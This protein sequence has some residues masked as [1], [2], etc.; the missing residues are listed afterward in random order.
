MGFVRRRRRQLLLHLQAGSAGAAGLQHHRAKGTLV[1]VAVMRKLPGFHR[2]QRHGQAGGL[3]ERPFVVLENLGVA[4]R[5][6]QSPLGVYAGAAARLERS[7]PDPARLAPGRPSP[8][9]GGGAN[10]RPFSNRR[11]AQFGGLPDKCCLHV[12]KLREPRRSGQGKKGQYGLAIEFW[13][14]ATVGRV[15]G[16]QIGHLGRNDIRHN[17]AFIVP[18]LCRELPGS[19][20]NVAAS[21]A[22]FPRLI[23]DKR[24]RKIVFRQQW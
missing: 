2:P 13:P 16:T 19:I 3:G 7:Q 22:D 15:L 21:P 10:A 11:I 12:S 24:R 17:D 6:D 14:L 23:N 9:C 4:E 20:R 8:W 1:A 5:L 18:D